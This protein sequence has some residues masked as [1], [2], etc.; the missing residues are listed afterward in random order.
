MGSPQIQEKSPDKP[1]SQTADDVLK[2]AAFGINPAVIM[3]TIQ[4]D[5]ERMLAQIGYKQ[6]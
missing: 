4:D 3:A 2:Q 6:V 1:S 5:D